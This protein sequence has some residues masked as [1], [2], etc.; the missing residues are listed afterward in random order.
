MQ[1]V[2]CFIIHA[3]IYISAVALIYDSPCVKYENMSVNLWK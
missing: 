2:N 1:L 3:I